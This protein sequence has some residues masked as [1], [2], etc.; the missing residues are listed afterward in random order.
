M[1]AVL[2]KVALQAH[3]VRFDWTGLPMHWIPQ[4]AF[5]SHLLNVLHLLLPEGE[6][7]FVKAFAEALPLISDEALR[8]DVLGFIG[9]QGM[10]TSAHQGAGLPA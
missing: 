7:F 3:D 1:T 8:E 4:E 6:R 10:H 5:A 2:T 9:Q